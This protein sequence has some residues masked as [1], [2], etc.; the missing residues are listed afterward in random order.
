MLS[1]KSLLQR[2]WDKRSET[3][4]DMLLTIQQFAGE[5]FRAFWGRNSG[6]ATRTW[7]ISLILWKEVKGKSAS[8][9]RRDADF[10]TL[11]EDEHNNI[12]AALEWAVSNQ[13][14]ESLPCACC[15]H[16]V[17]HGKYE[18]ITE[19]PAAGWSQIRTL[20]DANEYPAIYTKILHPIGR[21]NWTQDPCFKKREPCWM[22]AW[23]FAQEWAWM[24]RRTWLRH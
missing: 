17:G 12:R 18:D 11:S 5:H 21:Y 9:A 19:K 4:F 2:S 15:G 6:H 8:H 1:D 7:N 24:V 13:K 14:T 16:W 20:P 10:M 3:R 23:Q 22:R